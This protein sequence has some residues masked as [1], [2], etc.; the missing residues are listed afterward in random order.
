[1]ALGTIPNDIRVPLV[2]IDI[3]NSMAVSGTPAQAQKILV[4]AQQLSSATVDALKVSRITGSESAIDAQYG[5]GSMMALTLGALR[6]ANSYTDVYAVGLA[7][8]ASG[9]AATSEHVVNSAAT[10]AGTWAMLIAGQS[11]QIG[12]AK[13]DEP[14]TIVTKAVAQINK[15]T[16]LPVTASV[17]ADHTDTLVLTCKWKGQTGNDLDVRCN[18]YD[19][20]TYPQGMTVTMGSFTGGSGT[21]DMD[22]VIAAI[23]DEWYNHI[24]MPYNDTQSLD[25]LRDEL[26][27]RWGP[28][29][30]IEGIAY[31][32]Y[33]G[34]FAQTGTFGSARN[35]YLFT[36][37]GSGLSPTPTWEWAAAYAGTSAYHLAIDPARP[38][39]TLVLPGVLP[40]T[41][42]SRWDLTER[43]LLLHDGIATY[44]VTPGGQVAIEREISMYRE[45][46]YGD[47]DPSYLDITTPAT[48]G[49]LRYSMR[50]MVTNRFPRHKLADD[51][52]LPLLDPAQPV[53]TPKIMRQAI[54][55]KAQEWVS[56]GLIED[57]ELFSSTL[58]V[59]RDTN[60]RNRLN[61]VAHPDIVNQLR[62]FA[63]LI[64][65]KL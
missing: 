29:K 10:A 1:M 45:N 50:V 42:E 54:L 34:T 22:T 23:P 30:M 9:N 27:N 36:C 5:K 60:D 26:V 15:Q 16:R 21:P 17:K 28:L 47:P 61:C 43:N 4:V 51:D 6:K 64:Q 20:E 13:A 52:V 62:I 57:F 46:S 32:S 49:Y 7:D 33:R 38:L 8:L 41:K 2:Y 24:V 63:G 11:V 31:T 59:Y 56:A 55:E 48:L 44:S 18:Y 37:M 25:K 3:D 53:V 19:G 14:A 58:N 12:I 39:Q 65:F 40:P 35:D